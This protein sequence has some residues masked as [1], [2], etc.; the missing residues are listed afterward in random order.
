M[1]HLEH[2]VLALSSQRHAVNPERARQIGYQGIKGRPCGGLIVR[3]E[4][5]RKGQVKSELVGDVGVA[6]FRQKRVLTRCQPCGAAAGKFVGAGGTAKPVERAHAVEGQ[7]TEGGDVA[8]RHKRQELADVPEA[9]GLQFER[10]HGAG[11]LRRGVGQGGAVG[12][13]RKAEGRLKRSVK[14]IL[15]RGRREPVDPFHVGLRARRSGLNIPTK[16]GRAERR[17]S[18]ILRQV[19]D[20][21]PLET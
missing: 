5:A 13:L 15:A 2:A 12:S 6:P 10:R 21:K 7:L 11:E 4:L 9:K 3:A 18:R 17:Q 20:C 19:V 16:P 14:A 1:N 8:L